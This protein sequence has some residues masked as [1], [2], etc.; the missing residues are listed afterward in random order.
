MRLGVFGGSFDPVH[1]GHLLLAECC[2]EQL[3]LEKV[4]FIPAGQPPHK[5]QRPL[6]PAEHRVAMLE[7]AIGGEPGFE[8]C[9]YE[10]ERR[11]ISYTVETLRFLKGQFPQAE[12]F[13]LVGADMLNDLP[14]WREAAEIC[15]LAIP[16][17]VRRAGMPL[18][19]LDGLRAMMEPSRFE[20]VLQLQVDMPQI[21]LSASEIRARVASG[22]SIRFR[23]PKAVE[24]Y[25][26]HH[27]LYKDTPAHAA[28]T[29][30][31]HVC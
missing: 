20:R 7:L 25:I 10:I 22:K 18:P 1:Y 6:T 5:R 8:I 3:C 9:R 12:L 31:S 11:E 15:R 2:R 27:G 14:N 29:R 13:L 23:V 26:L 16:V 4:L 17:G 19:S 21:E 28:A 24:M 30:E